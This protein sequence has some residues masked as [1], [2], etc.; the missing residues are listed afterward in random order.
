[1]AKSMATLDS[2]TTCSS[3]NHSGR[4]LATG[5]LDGS[6][7][8][9]D[10][11]TSSSS[12]FTCTSKVRVSESSIVKIVWL[13]SEYGDAVACICEDGSLSTW[14]EL[15]EDSHA[16]EWKLCKSIKNK[17]SQVLDVQFGVSRKSLKMVAA[18]SDGYLRVFEL[19]N[20]L[21]LKNWQLQ[22]EF[23]N[24]IDSLSMLGKPS[25]LSA[26]VSWNPMKGEEQ[27]PSF[28]LAF[29]SDSPHL[30]SSKIWE[31]D[32][33]H[34]RWLAVAELAL[35]EDKGDP[36]YALSWA[37][38]IGRPYEVVAVAT[39]KGIGIWHVGLAPDLEGRLP[40][41]KVSSLSG[42]QGEVW[43]MEWDMSGMTLAS[44]GSDGMV[45][46][47]QSKLNGEW[48]E[49]ATLEPVPS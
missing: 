17:S 9:Y 49:Q 1:M 28:V 18:Y 31:F 16:L 11:S 44:T 14:E 38:N 36:V 48:H 20:P 26:S 35:P 19:L 13:P 39:H 24:V 10:S 37:P 6:F 34:N 41:K 2:G 23:Q 8:V 40:V 27:E 30:N 33:A 7:S 32:E 29:N 5:S 4:R 22:A 47:W 25:S 45:K 21:E 15:S 46:L 12:T 43:Q 3:W 42:H